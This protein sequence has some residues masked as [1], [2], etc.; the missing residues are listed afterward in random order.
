MEKERRY[1]SRLERTRPKFR[2]YNT[3]G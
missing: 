2:Q 3:D 1:R